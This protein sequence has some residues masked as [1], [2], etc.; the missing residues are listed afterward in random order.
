[1]SGLAGL[2]LP[3]WI[4]EELPDPPYQRPPPNANT[5][6]P[7]PAE[8]E[9]ERQPFF[10]F[11]TGPTRVVD[12]EE[13]DWRPT[14]GAAS[15]S[16][17]RREAAPQPLED[18]SLPCPLCG[19]W[20]AERVLGVHLEG[21]FAFEA[22]QELERRELEEGAAGSELTA[23]DQEFASKLQQ[24]EVARVLEECRALAADRFAALQLQGA[25]G[26]LPRYPEAAGSRA[27]AL[28]T[29]D[30]CTA[31]NDRGNSHCVA[32]ETERPAA[33]DGFVGAGASS[34]AM[35]DAALAAMLAAEEQAAFQQ[36][37]RDAEMAKRLSTGQEVAQPPRRAA[38]AA[39]VPRPAAPQ[40]RA[41]A[42]V[43]QRLLEGLR[44][45]LHQGLLEIVQEAGHGYP[46]NWDGTQR[47]A[48]LKLSTDSEEH[49]LVSQY[50]I[51]TLGVNAATIISVARLEN[52]QVYRRYWGVTGRQ[53]IMFHGCR[54]DQNEANILQN[55]FQVTRCVSGGANYGT[56]FAYDAA[57]SDGGFVYVDKNGERHIFLCVVSQ[58]EPVMENTTM[59]VVRQD[60]A[61]PMWLVVYQTR[62]DQGRPGP[63][64]VAAP[65]LPQVLVAGARPQYHEVVDGQWRAVHQPK[66]E[67]GAPKQKGTKR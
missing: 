43:P 65:A 61:Y 17:P 26:T 24:E 5:E 12:D 4:E 25:E 45:K 19:G 14:P 30:V 67:Q 47:R 41:T 60:G 48:S 42:A 3:P 8:E 53:T 38:A 28:W 58:D 54:S 23:T 16:A 63:Q 62:R 64:G 52:P 11:G 32:C 2:E 40:R 35:S 44:A 66:K 10:P 51:Y 15:S 33:L 34:S 36:L 6:P 20:Y 46:S 31:E 1:M 49:R 9:E 39:V 7:A 18:V 57:Y 13:F 59:R 55:G 21:H 50:L 56:W 22:T 29:C 27:P 37:Q